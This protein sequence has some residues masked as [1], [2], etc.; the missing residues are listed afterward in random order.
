[1][2]MQGELLEDAWW[3]QLV[4]QLGYLN[5]TY[6]AKVGVATASRVGY[7]L[8]GTINGYSSR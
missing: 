5:M 2:S 7:L 6:W 8:P 1:M 3:R 4:K